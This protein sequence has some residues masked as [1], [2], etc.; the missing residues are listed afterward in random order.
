MLYII[1]TPI[2]NLG[3]FS[4]RACAIIASCDY[5]LCEDTRRSGILLNHYS[6]KCPMKS[7]HAHNEKRMSER[8]IRDL[9]QGL[10]IGLLS[11]AGTPT[12]SDP[13]ATLVALCHEHELTV[14]PIPGP[15]AALTAL[16]AS[17]LNP[18][19]FQFLGFLPRRPGKA[20][21]LLK[22]SLDYP[23]TTIIYESPHRVKHTLTWLAELDP[24]RCLV[25]ARELTKKFE[26][27]TRG[28]A[29]DMATRYEQD[30]VLGEC[31]ILIAEK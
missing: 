12:L 16:C 3:D 8:V 21:K 28:S 23:G 4:P 19:R 10:T 27:F 24:E 17:G 9:Q 26:S 14:S 20:K 1:A 31:V 18:S 30:S 2:G 15:C 29:Q 7:F 11:D 13:G 22:E 5:L 25:L 6:L